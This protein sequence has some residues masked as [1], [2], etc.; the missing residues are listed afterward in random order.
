[1]KKFF[2]KELIIGGCVI[3]TL[4]ILFFGI[5]YLKGINVFKAANYYYVSYTNVAGLT[6]SAPVTVNGYKIGLVREI[7]YE[8]DNPGH[9]LVELSLDKQ[10]KVPRGSKAVLTTDMLGTSTIELQMA[11]STDYHS[12]G[13]KLIGANAIGL[14]DNITGELMPDIVGLMLKVDSILT[15]LAVI[16]SDPAL[17]Q[18]VSRL[19]LIMANVE[20][21]TSSLAVTMKNVQPASG[22]L[23][24]VINNVDQ[25]TAN[26]AAASEDLAQLAVN[27]KKL[28]LDSTIN[29][30]NAITENLNNVTA[31]LNSKESSL[32]MLLYDPALYNNLNSTAADLDSI[33]IDLKRQPKKYIPSIKVF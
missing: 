3:I 11:T 29:N 27:L 33:L 21:A 30:I 9:V 22:K 20:T 10:L 6:Q 26:L 2:S 16:T 1:M 19:N 18:A 25:I 14:M 4:A 12:I 24:V 23:P 28:P 32:G 17:V 13:D 8:Y 31:A 5:D 15:S 7:S